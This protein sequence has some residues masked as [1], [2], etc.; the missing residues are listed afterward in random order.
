MVTDNKTVKIFSYGTLQYKHVQLGL[1]GRVLKGTK[2]LLLGFRLDQIKNSNQNSVELSGEETHYL[3]VYTGDEHE[4][5]RGMVYELTT[6]EMKQADAYECP[7][8]KR[9]N[10][11]LRSGFTVWLFLRRMP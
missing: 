1:F 4:T 10:V 5:I 7:D 3:A 6:D 9:I 2:D 11:K 8:Y